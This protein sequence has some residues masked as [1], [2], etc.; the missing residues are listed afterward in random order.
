MF[1]F[2]LSKRTRERIFEAEQEDL[3][4]QY[5]RACHTRY[6]SPLVRLWLNF[7]FAWRTFGLIARCCRPAI[8]AAAVAA[9]LR[10][11]RHN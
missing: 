9:I 5:Q 4:A 8:W 6:N 11:L 2:I 1:A 3:I 7:A 10:L